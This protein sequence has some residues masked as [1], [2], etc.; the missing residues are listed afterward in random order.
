MIHMYIYMI[1]IRIWYSDYIYTHYD[2]YMIHIYIYVPYNA[3]V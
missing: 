2:T 1:H 3:V